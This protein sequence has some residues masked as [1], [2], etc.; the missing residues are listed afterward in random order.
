[1]TLLK[2]RA[3]LLLGLYSAEDRRLN[4]RKKRRWN[5]DSTDRT[6]EDSLYKVVQI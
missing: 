3:T 2:N 1:M 4:T 5:D 6:A